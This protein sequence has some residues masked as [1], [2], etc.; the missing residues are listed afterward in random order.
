V[1]CLRRGEIFKHEFV[2]NLLLSLPVKKFENR[3]IFGDVMGKSM[4]SCFFDKPLDKSSWLLARIL[5]ST[6]LTSCNK[7]IL[8]HT[9]IQ[10]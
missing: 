1:T 2:A 4:V 7:E 8:V 5:L 9:C 6:Y 10:K 3:L